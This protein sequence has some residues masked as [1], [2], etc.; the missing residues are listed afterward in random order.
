[1]LIFYKIR[2]NKAKRTVMGHFSV[3][4][5]LPADN[6]PPAEE[7]HLCLLMELLSNR[8]PHST[9]SVKTQP[10]GFTVTHTQLAIF[11][12]FDVKIVS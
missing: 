7:S 3:T 2:Q 8:V 4:R 10:I 6:I 11:I 1:M 9:T 5:V 12:S